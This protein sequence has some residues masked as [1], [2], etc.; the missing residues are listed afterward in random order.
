V[1][2]NA[3]PCSS[4]FL[5]DPKAGLVAVVSSLGCDHDG[6][7]CDPADP[8]KPTPGTNFS[9]SG[10]VGIYD[11]DNKLVSEIEVARY[12]WREGHQHPHGALFLPNGGVSRG[13]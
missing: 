5:P 6:A 9:N 8:E 1:G 12:L 13:W 4:Q 2:S 10:A 3:L 7:A 11:K